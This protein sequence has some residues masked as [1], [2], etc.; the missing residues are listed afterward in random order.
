MTRDKKSD[1]IMTGPLRAADFTG[2]GV[3][4]WWSSGSSDYAPA[5]AVEFGVGHQDV[6]MCPDSNPPTCAQVAPNVRRLLSEQNETVS[7]L[8]QNPAHPVRVVVPALGAAV[9][10]ATPAPAAQVAA[11]DHAVAPLLTAVAAATGA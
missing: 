2:G 7:Y 11:T 3:M 1:L 5:V 9:V 10:A 4:C 6:N 8:I